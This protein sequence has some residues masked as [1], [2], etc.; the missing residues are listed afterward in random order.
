MFHFIPVDSGSWPARQTVELFSAPR[1]GGRM[2][3]EEKGRAMP[4]FLTELLP[5]IVECPFCRASLAL[6]EEERTFKRFRCP[7]C[8]KKIDMRTR[9][10]AEPIGNGAIRLS[11]F[12]KLD[13]GNTTAP[14]LKQ[15][16]PTPSKAHR[17]SP[18]PRLRFF[19][20]RFTKR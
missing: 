14:P 16:I 1:G 7:A 20:F 17:G 4:R 18:G 3:D 11:P 2:S 5:P 6:D 15:T 19:P 12:S 8:H 10:S 9:V 13:L